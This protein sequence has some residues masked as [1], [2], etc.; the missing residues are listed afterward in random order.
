MIIWLFLPNLR[1]CIIRSARL[2][3]QQPSLGHLGHV[4]VPK[5]DDTVLGHEQIGALDIPMDYF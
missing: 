3:L 2:R 5:L 1:T 4:E